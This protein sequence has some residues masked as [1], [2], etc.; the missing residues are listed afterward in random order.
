MH[1]LYQMHNKKSLILFLHPI[2]NLKLLHINSWL[3][4]TQLIEVVHYTIQILYVQGWILTT[5]VWMG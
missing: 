4:L 3:I 2:H 5:K 1:N